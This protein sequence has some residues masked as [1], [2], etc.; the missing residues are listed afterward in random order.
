MGYMFF[1]WLTM[2]Q[3]NFDWSDS[4]IVAFRKCCFFHKTK[5]V[6]I[7]IQQLL[8]HLSF[9]QTNINVTLQ[10][11]SIQFDNSMGKYI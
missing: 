10:K 6:V 1:H 3:G 4:D 7:N 11:N 9:I 8:L 5:N 2:N